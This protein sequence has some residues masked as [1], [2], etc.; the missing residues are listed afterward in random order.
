MEKINFKNLFAGIVQN[1]KK[2]QIIKIYKIIWKNVPSKFKRNNTWWLGKK[3]V[4]IADIIGAITK[5]IKILLETQNNGKII[6]PLLVKR[7]GHF[8]NNKKKTYYHKQTRSKKENNLII[9][10]DI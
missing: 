7:E 2:Y 3:I 5:G 8:D 9:A 4:N 6:I 10:S 1:L